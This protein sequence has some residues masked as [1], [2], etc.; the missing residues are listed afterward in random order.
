M[1]LVSIIIPGY[2]A[3]KFIGRAIQSAIAQTYP[4]IE[5]I[6]A[7]DGST[8]ETPA[9]ARDKLGK[10]FK[11]TW[12]V[13]EL[14]INKGVSAARNAAIRAARGSWIQSLDAD[15]I[16]A[17]TKIEKQMAACMDA[18]A[19]V[20]AV[21]SPWRQVFADNEEIEWGGPFRVPNLEGK[22]PIMNLVYDDRAHHGAF[23]IRSAAL[24][25]IGGFDESLRF[26]E[27]LEMLVRLAKQSGRFIFVPSS[28]PLYLWR[29]HRH[30]PHIGGSE[31][32][33]LLKDV[34][35]GWI[36]QALKA[37][38]NRSIDELNL[39]ARDRRS[40]LKDCTSFARLLYPQHRE[41]FREY[42]VKARRLDPKFNP[43]N[44][45]YLSLLSRCIGYE[46]AE[47][48]AQL[49]RG[50]RN[51]VRNHLRRA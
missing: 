27:D 39:P 9:V 26:W 51:L 11:G 47:A 48:V 32:R 46:N 21:F 8:D 40:V 23:L 41:A 15:D 50:P 18:P 42:L 30:K 45:W 12:Q 13:I 36:D 37:A 5:I 49:A 34:A 38:G 24:A 20:A 3:E 6:V 4:H 2:N 43:T 25:Q 10:D 19:D 17:P 29:I 44:P 35:V 22:A 1:E 14:G 31:A 7:D 33:Y 28:E 16:L